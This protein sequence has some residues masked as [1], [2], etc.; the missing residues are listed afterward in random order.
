MGTGRRRR[1]TAGVWVCSGLLRHCSDTWIQGCV[2]ISILSY[3]YSTVAIVA[4]VPLI[5][6]ITPS[7]INAT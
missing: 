7:G 1:T 5:W 4:A 3:L 6:N 2:M